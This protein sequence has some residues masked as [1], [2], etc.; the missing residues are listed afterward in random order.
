MTCW[1]IVNSPGYEA[2]YQEYEKDHLDRVLREKSIEEDLRPTIPSYCPE[3]IA[4][5]IARCWRSDP[6]AR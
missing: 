3:T 1:E 4:K 2:P 6:A 5:M